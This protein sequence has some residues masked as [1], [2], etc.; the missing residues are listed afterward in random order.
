MSTWGQGLQEESLIGKGDN[1]M[2]KSKL[3][4]QV[5]QAE[6]CTPEKQSQMDQESKE[7]LEPKAKNM[8]NGRQESI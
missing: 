6:V 7:A 1:P 5:R 2:G 8:S 4:S 3:N